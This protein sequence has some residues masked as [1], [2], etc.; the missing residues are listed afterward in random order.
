MVEAKDYSEKIGPYEVSFKLPDEIA[1]NIEVN[2]TTTTYEAL[3]GT[4][5]N[6]YSIDLS[7]A[8]TNR[9]WGGFGVHDYNKSMTLDLDKVIEIFKRVGKSEGYTCTSAYRTIDGHDGIIVDC[10]GSERYTEKYIFAYQQD[11]HT[12]IGGLLYL[13]WDTAVLP[14]LKSLHVKEV[15]GLS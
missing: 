1:S 3:N 5:F 13:D 4:L 2:K 11:N 6:Q 15:A 14:F 12:T 8:G 9:S 7:I 10:F